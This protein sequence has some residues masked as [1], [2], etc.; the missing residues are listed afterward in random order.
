MAEAIH[1]PSDGLEANLLEATIHANGSDLVASEEAKPLEAALHTHDSDLVAAAEDFVNEGCA[2]TD[3]LAQV[4]DSDCAKIDGTGKLR[5]VSDSY[6]TARAKFEHSSPTATKDLDD[7]MVT[8]T[9]VRDVSGHK[10]ESVNAAK[11]AFERALAAERAANEEYEHLMA[12]LRE[13]DQKAYAEA[14]PLPI[15]VV[16]SS[17]AAETETSSTSAAVSPAVPTSS[18]R[19]QASPQRSTKSTDSPKV[20]P[21]QRRTAENESPPSVSAP[22]VAP[23]SAAVKSGR[24]ATPVKSGSRRPPSKDSTRKVI[25]SC[26]S[27]RVSPRKLAVS[28]AS[29]GDSGGG[30]GGVV[31]AG[32]SQHIRAFSPRAHSPRTIENRAGSPRQASTR[33][34][35][36]A[37]AS[38]MAPAALGRPSTPT[39]GRKKSTA[40]LEARH[41]EA[42]RQEV[43]RMLERN[44]RFMERL[45]AARAAAEVGGSPETGQADGANTVAKAASPTSITRGLKGEGGSSAGG[46]HGGGGYRS[47]A[48]PVQ[49]RLGSTG[50]RQR[51][52]SPA[53]GH[54]SSS[55]RAAAAAK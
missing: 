6:A 31:A 18:Q 51:P 14:E 52:P 37:G 5:R 42:K 13:L 53:R 11:D 17:P 43:R 46:V 41:V 55:A 12:Q 27:G 30:G 10:D 50:P 20:Q 7:D 21:H 26:G 33:G 47:S 54:N 49:A 2:S 35:A 19:L 4:D 23:P 22:V 8:D 32:A 34:A 29:G 9:V 39:G 15:V 16:D 24:P 3:V 44:R 38:S 40:E 28:G 48:G 45:V 36:G 25:P 1:L